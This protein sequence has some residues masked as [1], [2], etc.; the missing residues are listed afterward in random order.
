MDQLDR[1][2]AFPAVLIFKQVSS[3]EFGDKRD[4]IK[5]NIVDTQGPYSSGCSGVS[6]SISAKLVNEDT[7]KR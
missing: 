5:M 7:F 1:I 3:W 6:T 4:F 2:I